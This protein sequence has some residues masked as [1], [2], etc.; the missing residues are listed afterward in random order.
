MEIALKDAG[1]APDDV[2]YINAH[3][4]STFYNDKIETM[5][6]KKVFGPHATKLLISSTKPMTGHCLGGTAGIET[7]VAAKVLQTGDVPAT[8]NY[9]TPDPECD[10][11]YVPNKAVHVDEPLKA[12]LT[13]TLGFGG[14]NAALV[15]TPYK[16]L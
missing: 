2:G 7:V 4:T 6:I 3:G 12:V 1:I 13:D 8:L 15:L 5:A 11:N 14:H 10:L 9:S 16:K